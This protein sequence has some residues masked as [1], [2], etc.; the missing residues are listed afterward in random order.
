MDSKIESKKIFRPAGI[1]D[2]AMGGIVSKELTHSEKGS[3]TLFAFDKEQALSEHSAPFDAIV[4]VIEGKVALTI[5]K[6]KYVLSQG[7]MIVMPANHP[8]SVTAEEKFKM[9][10][11]MIR[12]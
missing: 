5:D 11:T 3:I 8:H 10:L 6:E 1:I 9:M 12:G 2:Y 7:E 4:Q